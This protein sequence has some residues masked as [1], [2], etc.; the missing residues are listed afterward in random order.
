MSA[1]ERD[2]GNLAPV[3]RIHQTEAVDPDR[4]A[5][6]GATHAECIERSERVRPE[7][8]AGADLGEPPRPL[9][10]A[11]RREGRCGSRGLPAQ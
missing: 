7:L 4:S 11:T 9:Q 6:G 3:R 2:A 1:L 5:A 8:D 10:Y